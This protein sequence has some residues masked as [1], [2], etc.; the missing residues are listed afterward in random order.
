MLRNICTVRAGLSTAAEARTVSLARRAVIGVDMSNVLETFFAKLVSVATTAI[1]DIQPFVP[2]AQ[3]IGGAVATLDPAAAPVVAAVEAGAASISAIAPTAVQQAQTA[4]TAVQNI[5][6][7]ASPLLTE[8][9]SL[10]D[11]IFHITPVPGGALLTAKTAAATVPVGA[12]L[13]PAATA[14]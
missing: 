11:S 13:T 9:E 1:T 10:W 3:E 4:I 14:N 8:F 7:S 12:T 5:A 2:I 6:A